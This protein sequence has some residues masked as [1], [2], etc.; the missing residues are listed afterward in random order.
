MITEKQKDE[1]LEIL[2]QYKKEQKHC[3]RANI[4]EDCPSKDYEN[5]MPNGDCQGDGHY[6]CLCC[7]KYDEVRGFGNGKH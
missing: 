7:K 3:V 6:L 4:D 2:E 1:A 5:G